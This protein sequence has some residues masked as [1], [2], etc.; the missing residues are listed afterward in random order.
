MPKASWT[1]SRELLK[2]DNGPKASM[3]LTF[4]GVKMPRFEINPTGRETAWG[5]RWS[6]S[7]GDG[8]PTIDVCRRCGRSYQ[9]GDDAPEEFPGII[10]SDDV[11]H[12]PYEDKSCGVNQCELCGEELDDTDD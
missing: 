1:L 3:F 11:A 5:R 6:G 10:T 7:K 8:Y 2:S 12:P 4:L 9:Q